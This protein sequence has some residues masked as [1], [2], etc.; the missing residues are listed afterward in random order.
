MTTMI[1]TRVFQGICLLGC[2][3]FFSLTVA[4]D[5]EPESDDFIFVDQ[6]PVPKN[7]TEI[8]R[9]IEYPAEAVQEGIAGTVVARV[10]VDKQGEYVRHKIV[11]E[12]HPALAAAVG[13][14]LPGLLF[15]PAKQKGDSVMYWMNIPFPFKLV[16]EREDRIKEMIA[17]LTD[18]LTGSPEDYTLWH[19]RG[20]QRSELGELN[21]A[22]TD[23]EESLR[24]NP[25]KNKKK[26]TRDYEYLFYSQYAKGSILF[27]QEKYQE[28]IDLYTA[29][30]QATEEMKGYDSAVQA[31]VPNVYIDRGFTHVAMENYEAANTDYRWA[32]ENDP[33]QECDIYPLLADVGLA[34]DDN[35]ALVGI[36]DGLIRCTPDN[37]LLYY[38]R[39]FYKMESG[40]LEG[41][42]EDF[43]VV[44]EKSSNVDIKIASFNQA[45]FA[46]M[47]MEAYDKAH[48]EVENALGINAL[49]PLAY[50][51]QSL[52]FKAEEKSEDACSSMR[53][54]LSFGLEGDKREEAIALMEADCGGWED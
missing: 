35:A 36:Y 20:I 46:Y 18:S 2:L 53:R 49:N 26:K 25:R 8:R 30:I 5:A 7:L 29:A 48:Q 9:K 22:L 23:F 52:V 24:V 19:K 27:K 45:A 40:D 1:R 28:A 44:V 39:G 32:L 12:I 31:S 15:E 37:D 47:K 10:L 14:Y 43:Q 34:T 38:S 54:A 33:D 13:K 4:Q 3:L 16:N 21:D 6:E 17:S 50:Y 42:V 51:Y 11:K 41:A